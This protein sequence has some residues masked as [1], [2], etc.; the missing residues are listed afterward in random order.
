VADH[1]LATVSNPSSALTDFTL[2]VDLSTMP[3]NWWSAV[4]TSDGTRGR[5][6]K[7]DGTTRLAADWIDFD[8]TA[9]TGLLRVL[10]SGTLASTGTQQLWIEPPF[11]GNA[12]V[13]AS[14]TYGSDNAYDSSWEGYWPDGGGTDRTSNGNDGTARGGV[15]IG[16]GTGPLGPGT[17]LDGTDDTIEIAN[18]FQSVFDD[19]DHTILIWVNLDDASVNQNILGYETA[20]MSGGDNDYWYFFRSESSKTLVTYDDDATKTNIDNGT[21]LS[22]STWYQIGSYHDVAGAEY[23]RWRNASLDFTTS[24]NG[25]IYESENAFY[26]GSKAGRDSAY[27]DGTVAELQLH[28]A[29]RS[30][31][32]ISHEYDQTSDNATFWGTWSWETSGGGTTQELIGTLSGQGGVSAALEVE[33]LLAATASA[34]GAVDAVLEVSRLLSA[35][36]S[37]TAG[38][39]ADIDVTRA[40][41][42]TANGTGDLSGLLTITRSLAAQADG[43]TTLSGAISVTRALAG[44]LAATGGTDAALSVE[45]IERLAGTLSGTGGVDAAL[46]IRRALSGDLATAGDVA[47][48]LQVIRRLSGE[49]V[50]QAGAS[51]NLQVGEIALAVGRVTVALEA[52]LPGVAFTGAKPG[53]AFDASAPG[54]SWEGN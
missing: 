28:S 6:Y 14:D 31:A 40:L 30:S 41:S 5:V 10:W 17:E 35:A 32:W 8:D 2:I 38:S 13:G 39:S 11:S 37:G 23:G 19:N 18:G 21:A 44:T 48:A 15:T 49:I 25:S 29:N 20:G 9:E 33:R 50:G 24:D 36:A 54:V 1:A 3:A 47:A 4:D 53:A 34:T 45:S 51:G 26:V 46:T 27:T 12:T 16:A 42:A 52:T 7:G 43:V 22:S